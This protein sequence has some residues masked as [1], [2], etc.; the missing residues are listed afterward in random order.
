MRVN[1][2]GVKLM[3]RSLDNPQLFQI[4]SFNVEDLKTKLDHSS[5]LE[6][7]LKYDMEG[8]YPKK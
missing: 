4:L 6:L 3:C 8:R 7:I 1:E 5:F 2:S